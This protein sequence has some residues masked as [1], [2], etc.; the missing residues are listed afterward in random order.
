MGYQ[1]VRTGVTG[2]SARIGGSSDYHIDTKLSQSLPLAQRVQ[3]FDALSRR[4][5]QEGRTIEFSNQGVAGMQWD[6]NSSMEDKMKLYQQATAAHAPRQGFDSL[7]YY[8][9]LAGKDRFDVSAEGAP[10]YAPM[11][12]GQTVYQGQGG[13]YGRFTDISSKDGQ[14]LFRS[15][16]GDIGAAAPDATPIG[17]V[18]PAAPQIAEAT[19]ANPATNRR[20]Q[21]PV[22]GDTMGT[23][24]KTALRRKNS[25]ADSMK[26][27]F[28]QR[29]MSEAINPVG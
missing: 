4:Y 6:P 29:I 7:D 15:G 16:H 12:P 19:P 2:P 22:L 14:V 11:M 5:A 23:T 25:L 28:L 17:G 21:M 27:S 26:A 1:F 13:G 10:I 8:A 9:P 3:A 18:T 24:K 20:T